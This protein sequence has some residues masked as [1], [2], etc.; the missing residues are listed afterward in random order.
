MSS[1]LASTAAFSRRRLLQAGLAWLVT[2]RRTAFAWPALRHPEPRAG[3]TAAAV[4]PASRFAT[5]P[6]VSRVFDMARAIPRVFDGLACV[7]D[8]G[9]SMSHRSLLACYETEQ[10]ATCPGCQDEARLA[11]RLHA[12]G[13]SLA[14]IREAVDRAF[15]R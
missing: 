4:L 9:H 5:D 7:C 1:R 12:R 8:C 13:E 10:P 3:V 14:Q 11:H 2:P 6:S 15:G